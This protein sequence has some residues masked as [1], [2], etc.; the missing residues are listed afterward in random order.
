MLLLPGSVARSHPGSTLIT[1]YVLV[2]PF[3]ADS[4]SRLLRVS[5]NAD[6]V[7]P[8]FRPRSGPAVRTRDNELVLVRRA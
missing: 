5:L 2:L 6:G 1:H 8:V 3:T 4:S 7:L